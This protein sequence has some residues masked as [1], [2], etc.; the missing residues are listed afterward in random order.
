MAVVRVYED[1][2]AAAEPPSHERSQPS[3]CPCLGCMRMNDLRSVASHD[4]DERDQRADVV[5]ARIPAQVRHEYRLH[6]ELLSK[7]IHASLVFSRLTAHE[8]SRITERL[9]SPSQ[10]DGLNRGA[11]DVEPSDD[12]YDPDRVSPSAQCSVRVVTSSS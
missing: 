10:I 3:E 8:R 6:T 12:P 11:A 9:E 1:R 5:P 7:V 4:S 2:S